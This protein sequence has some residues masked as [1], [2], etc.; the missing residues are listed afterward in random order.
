VAPKKMVLIAAAVVVQAA[1]AWALTNWVIGPKVRGEGFPWEREAEEVAENEGDGHELGP[2]LPIEEVTVNV[3]GTK[4]RR[5][6]RTSMTLEMEGKELAE[7]AEEWM[8]VF[9]GRVIDLL[10]TKDMDQLTAPGARDSLKV[11]ILRTLNADASG[12][13]F[14][15]L[16]F[17]EFLVQ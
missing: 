8:P 4:G 16:F 2:L 7:K 1:A 14:R 15:D 11:E 5:F 6:C 9:R 10:S 13:H 3:A 17:T 12:G